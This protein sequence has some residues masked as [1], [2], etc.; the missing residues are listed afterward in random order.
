MWPVC[1]ERRSEHRNLWSFAST[2]LGLS[3][4]YALVLWDIVVDMLPKKLL[5]LLAYDVYCVMCV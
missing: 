5:S 2:T 1:K 3:C 4:L